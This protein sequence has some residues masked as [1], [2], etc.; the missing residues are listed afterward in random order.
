MKPQKILNCLLIITCTLFTQLTT[1]QNTPATTNKTPTQ[2]TQNTPLHQ[3]HLPKPAIKIG[4]LHHRDGE[5]LDG[6]LSP[7]GLRIIIK[8]YTQRKPVEVEIL[9]KDGTQEKISRSP[10][11]I[12]EIP[13][14]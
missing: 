4:L 14:L 13:A 1:A 11:L 12:D 9:F 5:V 7:D 2:N 8:N 3:L 6:Q 10:C